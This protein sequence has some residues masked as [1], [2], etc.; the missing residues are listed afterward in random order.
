MIDTIL[1]EN[2]ITYNRCK[3][4]AFYHYQEYPHNLEYDRILKARYNK[5]SRVRKRLIYLLYHNQY[6]YFI[7]FTFDNNYIN[8]CDRTKRD[9]IKDSLNSFCSDCNYILNIDF[10]SK[11]EREHYHCIL[12]TNEDFNL[13]DH[14]LRTYPCLVHVQKIRIDNDGIKKLSKYINKLS[15]HCCKDS[16]RNRRIVYNFK[17]YDAI[18]DSYLRFWL[19]M[20]HAHKLG[21]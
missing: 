3:R 2:I 17:G 18:K 1:E 15:N 19:C 4:N 9:L 7:T 14:L 20:K 13:L 11:N 16:T 8:K 10:G 21:L 12:G 5:V 6:N